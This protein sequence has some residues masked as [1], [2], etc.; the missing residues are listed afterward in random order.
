VTAV[1]IE[2][3]NKTPGKIP[4]EVSSML[5]FLLKRVL[6]NRKEKRSV[7]LTKILLYLALTI[8]NTENLI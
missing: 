5:S 3:L 2:P 4:D 8:L 6:Q 1:S 7:V